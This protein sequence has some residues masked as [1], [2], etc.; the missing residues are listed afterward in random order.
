MDV[1]DMVGERLGDERATTRVNVGGDDRVYVTAT[2][3]LVYRAGGFLSNASIEEFTH[4]S[5]AFDV[6]AGR[7]QASSPSASW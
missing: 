6:S 5:D 1:P 2:R 4:D 3:T 7:R